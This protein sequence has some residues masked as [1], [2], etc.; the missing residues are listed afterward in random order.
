[1][2]GNLKSNAPKDDKSIGDSTSLK[3][4]I[5][6]FLKHHPKF[7]YDTFIRNAAFDS[8]Q[9]YSI[10]IKEI[11]YQKAVIPL[12]SRNY[13]SNLSKGFYDEN[14]WPT[15]PKDSSLSM[16]PSGWCSEKGRSPRHK[17]TCP[18]YLLRSAKELSAVKIPL[19][20]KVW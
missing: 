11:D 9:N 20:I 10:S 12:N 2:Q 15:C 13:N 14:G 17:I 4:A 8:Y 6:D 5:R 19:L 7:T 18:K 1:M 16:K 3:S